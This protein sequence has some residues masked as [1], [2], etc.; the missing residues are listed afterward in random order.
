MVTARRLSATALN[1][2]S[3]PSSALPLFD[4]LEA[5]HSTSSPTQDQATQLKYAYLLSNL[6]IIVSKRLHASNAGGTATIGLKSGKDLVTILDAFRICLDNLPTG[7]LAGDSKGKS[8]ATAIDLEDGD[9]MAL[10]DGPASISTSASGSA[11]LD[12]FTYSTIEQLASENLLSA[13]VAASTRYSGTSRPALSSFLVAL[14]Y[15]WPAKR[16]TIVNTLVYS[17]MVAAGRGVIRE[18]WRG[19]I[20]SS[21][22]SKA[23]SSSSGQGSTNLI[24]TITNTLNSETYKDEWP[25]LILLAELYARTLLTLGDDEFFASTGAGPIRG[26]AAVSRNPL[27]ID[28]VIGLS[29]IFR[30]LAFALYWFPDLLK[31][32]GTGQQKYVVGSKVSVEGL[33]S[34]S[35]QLLQ[36][37]HARE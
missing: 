11:G 16:E 26:N 10:D 36:M 1:S 9:M 29:G 31:D 37:I 13:I 35:T 25:H 3:G 30:N 33:R 19:W 2:I 15:S 14:I 17:D 20:R 24:T 32:A 8:A 18:L 22:L 27:T 21:A 23:I 7:L 28:E 5:L 6:I 34:L 4:L 12:P